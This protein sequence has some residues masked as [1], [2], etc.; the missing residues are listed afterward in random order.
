MSESLYIDNEAAPS[1]ILVADLQPALFPETEDGIVC[2]ADNNL[3]VTPANDFAF[4]LFIG[5]RHHTLVVPNDLDLEGFTYLE[6]FHFLALRIHV[7]SVKFAL[8]INDLR[9]VKCDFD[10][11]SGI[12]VDTGKTA[13]PVARHDDQFIDFGLP[14]DHLSEVTQRFA[15]RP[16]FVDDVI[17]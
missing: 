1:V 7:A 12:L 8:I 6:R 9:G 16:A 13:L 11:N 3:A 4:V 14:I 17:G 2:N 15:H 10:R 5:L